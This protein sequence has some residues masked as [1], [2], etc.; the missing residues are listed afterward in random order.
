MHIGGDIVGLNTPDIVGFGSITA[1]TFYGDGTGL[2]NTGAQMS[3]PST[4]TQRVVL[5]DVFSGTMISGATDTTLTFNFATDT[6]TG[7]N[8]NATTFTGAL[9]GNVTGNVTGN[10]DSAT[11]AANLSFGTANQ[12]VFKN[13]SND[14]ATSGNLTFDGNHLI[15]NDGDIIGKKFLYLNGTA[16][17]SGDIHTAGGDD[18]I[19]VIQSTATNGKIRIAG[20]NGSANVTIASFNVE[21]GQPIL[22]CDGDIVAFQS[23][24]RNLKENITV[25]PNALDKINA[26]SGNTFNWKS[27]SNATTP[28]FYNG[29]TEDTGVIAQE[30]EAL[31][32]PGITTTRDDGTKAVR[33]ER[34]VPVLIQAV[35][36]LSV[37]VTA[38]EGS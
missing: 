25:I 1:A 22:R 28:E 12:V 7:T 4:G 29:I 19:A 20:N 5:T 10:A 2:S 27:G 8:I 6:L 15:V 3:E 26:I 36:E 32:L 13:A 34:L 18:G 35:K 11:T 14:G 33:Y 23:S 31:G 38:L 17:N 24:D 37:K 21:S 9:T 30:V 16:A